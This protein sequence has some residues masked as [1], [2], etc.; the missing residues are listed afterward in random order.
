MPEDFNIKLCM[1]LPSKLGDFFNASLEELGARG[2]ESI[3]HRVSSPSMLTWLPLLG[4]EGW[5]GR[6][7]GGDG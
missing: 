4:V 3:R 6:E 7:E 1:Y 2:L 5:R